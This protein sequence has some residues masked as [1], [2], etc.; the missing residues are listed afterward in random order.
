MTQHAITAVSRKAG[1]LDLFTVRDDG[2]VWTAWWNGG[3]WSDWVAIGG[4]FPPGAR[5]AA[6]ARTADNLDLFVCGNDGRVYTAWWFEGGGWSGAADNWRS[7]G[8]FFPP[9]A[10]V[11]ATTRAAGNLDLFIC[12]NDGRVYTSWWYDGQEWSGLNDSWASVGGFFPPGAPVAAVARSPRNLDLFITGNDGRVWT[13]W[14][15][16]GAPDW[17]SGVHDNWMSVGGFF[18]VGAPVAAVSRAEGNLDLFVCGNDGRV[19][20]AWWTGAGGWSGMA[21]NWMSVGGFFP[22]GAPVAA[23]SRAE[24]NLD[25]FVCGN[26]GRVYTA[27]WTGAGGWSGMADNWM[28]VGGYFPVAAP[29]AAVARAS[30]NLDLFVIGNDLAAYTSWWFDGAPGWSGAADNWMLLD[31]MH[32]RVFGGQITSGGLAALGGWDELTIFDDGGTRFRG[33]AHD[34]G[35]DGYD[36]GVSAVLGDRAGHAVAVAHHGHVGGTFTSGSRD[37]DWDERYPVNEIVRAHYAAFANGDVTFST[38]YSSDL[39]SAV[40]NTLGFLTKWLVGST[41]LGAAIG[42]VVFVGV[43]V[44]SLISTGSL[45]PGARVVGGVLWLAGPSNTLIA[46]AAEGIASA[47]SRERE[48]TQDEYD[49][50]DHAVF[51]GTLPPRDRIVLTDT[52]GGNDRAFTFPRFDGKITVNMG[53]AC[54]DDPRTYRVD[55]PDPR[56]KRVYGETFVHELVHAWQ[57]QHAPTDLGLLADALA[58]KVCEATG[59]DPYEYGAAGPAFSEFNLEQ[60]ASIVAGWFAG[61]QGAALDPAGPYFRYVAQNIRTGQA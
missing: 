53:A 60:Q 32:Q 55:H 20:T 31:R 43:E 38:N 50:A 15:Y 56:K 36:F 46:L 17:W 54:Y 34:S 9:G 16:E 23:V 21:D 4:F 45:V 1:Q 47:G 59:G 22:V 7:I 29:L 19:Y 61:R 26:D 6:V 30:G 2:R 5:V 28:S 39:G 57:I 11:A 10:P 25:L 27:W 48:L 35:A 14:W 41:P 49:F 42:L 44:G 3:G 8:G 13:S 33:H 37:H 52:I 12:G 40:E 51:Q 24:G 18:P 58:S